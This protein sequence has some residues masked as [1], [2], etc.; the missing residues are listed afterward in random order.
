[1]REVKK[2][3]QRKFSTF[4]IITEGWE[5]WIHSIVSFSTRCA[6]LRTP[7]S[8]MYLSDCLII[9]LNACVIIMQILLYMLISFTLNQSDFSFGFKITST[10]GR[11]RAF[12][13]ALEDLFCCVKLQYGYYLN[14]SLSTVN[15]VY[16][17][18]APPFISK[19]L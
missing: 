3:L 4:T 15:T 6:A 13:S 5:W 11:I 7:S 1:M 8:P 2:M 14:N 17:M 16:D 18:F 10:T 19:I 9:L 12:L